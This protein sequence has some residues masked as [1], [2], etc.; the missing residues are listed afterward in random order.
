MPA[1]S[2]TVRGSSASRSRAATR[3]A[4]RALAL[5]CGARAAGP[6]RPDRTTASW[7]P[8]SHLPLI[9]SVALVEAVAG[10]ATAQAA[11]WPE[12]SA[13]AA[14]GWRD[15]T[16]LARGDVTMGTEIAVTNAAA[17]RRPPARLPR[18][19]RRVDRPA[20][21][22]RRPGRGR[23]MPG[24]PGR[25]AAPRLEDDGVGDPGEQVLVVPR[26]SIV[27]GEGWLGVRRDGIEAALGRRGAR[28][29]VRPP[30]G[31][32]GGPEP[33]AG[34]PVPRPARRRTLVPDAADEGR[35]RR[36]PARPV[37]DRRR[38]PPEPGRRRRHGRTPPRMGGGARRRLRAGLRPRRAAQRRHDAPWGPSTW[39]SCTS[40]TP[41]A[42]PSPIR[43][44][45][46]LA[47]AFATTAEVAAVRD[48]METWSRLVFDVLTE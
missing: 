7:R 38:R 25:G 4:V 9:A 42:G 17:A 16:R 8:I 40:P 41:P 46:K 14:S 29:P 37:V 22:A 5:A 45:E 11:D 18:P 20:R 26:E 19:H 10:T 27:P 47:G 23:P 44:T 24:T 35:G 39:A 33:E 2:A 15:T 3:T 36:A 31:G 34:H 32:R 30:L 12:A 28:G 48:S 13:L 43:E 6:G 1:S 21:G